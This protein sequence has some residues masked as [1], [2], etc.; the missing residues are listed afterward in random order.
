[1]VSSEDHQMESSDQHTPPA[2]VSSASLSLL[3]SSLA[4]KHGAS[5]DVPAVPSP[6]NV[7]FSSAEPQSEGASCASPAVTSSFTGL[8]THSQQASRQ[9]ATSSTE[10]SFPAEQGAHIES[11]AETHAG[12]FGACRSLSRGFKMSQSGSTPFSNTPVFSAS[13]DT[14]VW[15]SRNILPGG[16]SGNIMPRSSS[17]NIVPGA[18]SSKVIPGASTSRVMP[19]V[20]FSCFMPGASSSNA[21]PRTSSGNAMPRAS[22][23]NAMPGVSSS[24]TLPGGLSQ[25]CVGQ[26]STSTASAQG[27]ELNSKTQAG[28]LGNEFSGEIAT[29]TAGYEPLASASDT[30]PWT[31]GESAAAEQI[32]RSLPGT[33]AEPVEL[34]IPIQSSSLI[35]ATEDALWKV[36]RAASI[37]KSVIGQWNH[38]HHSSASLR[39]HINRCSN[40]VTLL[41]KT[42]AYA[43]HIG[44][45]AKVIGG[46]V[47]VAGFVSQNVLLRG[48]GSK[49]WKSGCAVKLAGLAGNLLMQMW[50]NGFQSTLTA[51][52]SCLS[53]FVQNITLIRSVLEEL[54]LHDA[55][56]FLPGR[57]MPLLLLVC[58]EDLF[59]YACHI[60][61]LLISPDHYSALNDFVTMALSMF[62]ST[63]SLPVQILHQVESYQV[64]HCLSDLPQ[65][66]QYA[67]AA[68]HV[69]IEI[70]DLFS[71]L[72]S[73]H[74]KD[75]LIMR[76]L[77]HKLKTTSNALM[78][79]VNRIPLLNIS[80]RAHTTGSETRSQVRTHRPQRTASLPALTPL[81]M[82]PPTLLT[83]QLHALFT[84]P[85]AAGTREIEE[86]GDEEDGAPSPS[87]VPSGSGSN[88][89]QGV[90]TSLQ[91]ISLSPQR[92]HLNA[93]PAMEVSTVVSETV[94][95][96]QD[97]SVEEDGAPGPS[98][99]RSDSE[100]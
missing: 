47:S 27:Q 49:M 24:N 80:S 7:G 6:V 92:S 2:D 30:R 59:I 66:L 89:V 58:P 10:T 53:G 11:S 12:T 41:Q 50:N 38:Y 69:G 57:F 78:D 22:S 56:D 40:T 48:I 64:F 33:S 54:Q 42:S 87:H 75:F 65:P 61:R 21:V 86:Q 17:G 36:V 19:G 44:T 52:L 81:C 43:T 20:S 5:F 63:A 68:A 71:S 1:M 60:I 72:S 18:S 8:C 97:R 76:N 3:E 74:S 39:R 46:L 31:S 93:P 28:M 100:K 79:S 26:G 94:G 98:N 73:V 13:S 70:F 23:G 15:S 84:A 25:D 32:P 77:L 96:D 90:E 45:T 67:A 55:R 91:N 9:N 29:A 82:H 35:T 99:L 95:G 51:H 37:L 62:P 34:N 16:S 14:Y 85:V 88:R 4:S 83:A